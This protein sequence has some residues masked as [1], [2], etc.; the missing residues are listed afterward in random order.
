MKYGIIAVTVKYYA[1]GLAMLCTCYMLYQQNEVVEPPLASTIVCIV[2]RT[3]ANVW[4]IDNASTCYITNCFAV[5]LLHAFLSYTLVAVY[6]VLAG[7][8]IELATDSSQWEVSQGRGCERQW[9]IVSGGRTS[10][11]SPIRMVL[12]SCG[13]SQ[14]GIMIVLDFLTRALV[15][16]AS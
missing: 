4:M 1:Q 12:S 14:L 9:Y 5:L 3:G 16:T 10:P 13:Y 7:V 2:Y 15:D 8:V 6:S 11:L